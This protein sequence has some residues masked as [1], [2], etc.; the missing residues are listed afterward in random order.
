MPNG[1]KISILPLITP[2]KRG[3][4]KVSQLKILYKHASTFRDQYYVQK[5]ESIF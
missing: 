5:F 4:S 2:R 1:E 3:M